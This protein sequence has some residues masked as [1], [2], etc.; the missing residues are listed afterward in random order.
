MS[1]DYWSLL[2]MRCHCRIQ[3]EKERLAQL[4]GPPKINP[5][6]AATKIQKVCV[7]MIV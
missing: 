6:V 2:L 7:L 1:L 4:S 5:D 3:E